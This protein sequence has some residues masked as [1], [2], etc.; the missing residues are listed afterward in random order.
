[1]S[2]RLFH[3][4]L[5]SPKRKVKRTKPCAKQVGATKGRWAKAFSLFSCQIRSTVVGYPL[6]SYQ[7]VTCCR[8]ISDCDYKL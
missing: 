2:K 8:N 6:H 1:M 3:L 4:F 5:V 7:Q